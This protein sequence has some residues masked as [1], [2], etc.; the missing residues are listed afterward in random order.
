[1]AIKATD[2]KLILGKADKAIGWSEFSINK[3]HGKNTSRNWVEQYFDTVEI[4]QEGSQAPATYL[5]ISDSNA[6]NYGIKNNSNA[7]IEY[8]KAEF[9]ESEKQETLRYARTTSNA[10]LYC[11]KNTSNS[12]AYGIKNNSNAIIDI[13]DRVF[14]L[15]EKQE[16]I[17]YVRTTSNAFLYCCKNNSNALLFG[18]RNNSNAIVNFP[19]SALWSIQEKEDL[20]ETIRVNSNAFI[21]CCKNTSN[22][23]VSAFKIY[24]THQ[25]Y[26][27][28]ALEEN[29][30][31]YKAGFTVQDGKTLT[32]NTPTPV[33]GNINLSTSGVLELQGDLYM[34]ADAYLTSGGILDGN[35]Y[36]LVLSCS[37]A[38]PENQVVHITGD[39]VINGHGTTLYLEPHA[40]I[41]VDNNVT[42]TIKNTRIKS[43]RNSSS[44]PILS[45]AGSSG[46]I[47]LQNC[48]LALADDYY[49]DQGHLFIHDD[50]IITG[51]SAFVYTSN[52]V[53]YIDT[54]AT[55][56]F[57]KR[58]KFLYEPS[59]S[60]NALIRMYDATSCLY[61]DGATLQAGDMGIRLSTGALYL[62]NNVTLSSPVSPIIFGDS[63][64]LDSDLDV[65]VLAD[66][67]VEVTGY[68]LDDSSF[69]M[70]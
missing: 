20:Y 4:S 26:N 17:N 5:V 66:A 60:D 10:F 9:T 19:G 41:T 70:P 59:V 15:S 38:I 68:V 6:I 30:V 13:K 58:T 51:T 11:C 54:A 61:L 62:D 14:S 33:I 65:Y 37:F 39:T 44:D 2:S 55:W 42:L 24:E 3:K 25:V 63:S 56:C 36:S 46:K 31:F 35:G 28:D 12:L 22:A 57:D 47:A 32:I 53:S 21:Y 67:R 52:Q 23:F 29:Y 45:I 16:L 34:A 69:D 1:M 48:E 50:V 18:I 7:I 8:A 43:S 64:E 40:Q 49:L 27:Y